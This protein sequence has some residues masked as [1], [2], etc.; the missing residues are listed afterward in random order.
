MS[1]AL[2][3]R[4][5]GAGGAADPGPAAAGEPGA[6]ERMAA[7]SGAVGRE[8]AEL[9]ALLAAAER[10]LA[11]QAD[12][13]RALLDGLQRLQ[14]ACAP[15][16]EESEAG[17]GEVREA[18]AALVQVGRG[19]AGVVDVLGEVSGAAAEITR[20]AVQTRLVA[21]NAS[22][23]AKRAGDAGRG[24]AVV[25]DAVKDLAARVE[26][27]SV[28]IAGTVGQL[29]SRIGT[30]SRD[31]LDGGRG[32]VNAALARADARADALAAAARGQRS[33]CDAVVTAARALS[34]RADG[35]GRDARL[36][37]ARVG[38]LVANA[39][40]L[41]EAA[42]VV[43]PA[44]VDGTM[45]AAAAQAAALVAAVFEQAL[46]AGQTQ[47]DELFD[48]SYAPVRDAPPG[49]F[50]VRW[51]PLAER[52]LAPLQRRVLDAL[53]GAIGCAAIDRNGYLA[54]DTR[55]TDPASVA[56]AAARGRA[57]RLLDDRATRAARRAERPVL[58]L[59]RGDLDDG[60]SLP[61]KSVCVPILIQG[62]AW[63]TFRIDYAF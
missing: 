15:M 36:A 5:A 53:P 38:D 59:G 30:L 54:V 52:L 46:A 47:L 28:S 63:G 11:A 8:A 9:D 1:D 61:A 19:V 2:I 44:S 37:H 20:I 24:F 40:S 25:A 34:E 16:V 55:R 42:A 10:A 60:V 14:S 50:E 12:A 58:V 45:L 27:S 13:T 21:M 48:E 43:D 33:R 41:L 17:R 35:L 3:D 56:E 23:E 31:I 6:H 26:Q 4:E 22:V 49:S 39:A 18:R 29:Q 51:R 7:L 57:R 62:R 32:A